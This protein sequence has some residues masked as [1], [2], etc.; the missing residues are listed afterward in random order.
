MVEAVLCKILYLYPMGQPVAVGDVIAGKYRVDRVL[1]KGG[2]GVVVLATHL[3]LRKRRA[4]KLMLADA[5]AAPKAVERFLR[6][7]R[8]ACLLENEHI[9]HVFD[10]GRLTSGA[11]FIVMEYL[12]GNDLADELSRRGKIPLEE[13]AESA[14]QACIALAEAHGRGLVHRDLKPSNL[15][16]ARQSDGSRRIKVLDFGISKWLDKGEGGATTT[17]AVIGSPLYMSPE[18]IHTPRAIDGRA[19]IWSLGVILYELVTGRRPFQG[20]SLMSALAQIATYAPRPPSHH[21]PG[22]PAA[23]DAVVLRCLEKKPENRYRDVGELAWDLLP[24]ASP[25]A[26]SLA[27]RVER[28]LSIS[29]SMPPAPPSREESA[30]PSTCEMAVAS[31]MP[32]PQND[33]SAADRT[34]RITPVSTIT[35]TPPSYAALAVANV[36][37]M[38]HLEDN[39]GPRSERGASAE[40]PR[41]PARVRAGGREAARRPQKNVKRAL[42]ALLVAPLALGAGVLA[43]STQAP[44]SIQPQAASSA[45]PPP[46]DL[47]APTSIESSGPSTPSEPLPKASWTPP[48][49]AIPPPVSSA[50]SL[51]DS[52]GPSAGSPQAM[53]RP[54]APP[55]QTKPAPP[56]PPPVDKFKPLPATE[57]PPR[58]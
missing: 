24:F 17:D 42:F 35:I 4:I 20:E 14:L 49:S 33:G 18:Q 38:L 7:A 55:R 51:L 44:P 58:H 16:S 15:Y 13:V 57:P 28:V 2:M 48:P 5:S 26:R 9:A 6:E 54:P 41:E 1:G 3:E 53:P 36:P 21:V 52:S 43:I 46:P 34:D 56:P 11:P 27:E 19:D 40:E 45:V 32:S 23:F 12:E 10:V 8:A 50:P 22:L 29:A 39:G 37:A 25:A 47:A 31:T 30:E